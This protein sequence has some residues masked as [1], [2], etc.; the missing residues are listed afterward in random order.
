M[1]LFPKGFSGMGGGLF[2]GGLGSLLPEEA[3][4]FLSPVR[5]NK[6][7]LLGYLAGALQG[8]SLGESIGSG[9]QGMIAGS[10]ADSTAKGQRAALE[11]VAQDQNLPAD[12]RAAMVKSPALAM[13]YLKGFAKPPEFR[14]FDNQYGLS[15]PSFPGGY[16]QGGMIPQTKERDPSKRY[17]QEFPQAV[18]PGTASMI[19]PR[20]VQEAGPKFDDITA[21]RKNF[22]G[23]DE[24]KRWKQ[25]LPS[26]N[27]MVTA[28]NNP[29]KA[30]DL[31]FIYGI[32]KIFDPDSVVRE[33]EQYIIRNTQGLPSEVAAAVNR[34]LGDGQ[35]L[36]PAVRH[37]LATLGRDRMLE[38]QQQ[39]RGV[40]GQ[41]RGIAAEGKIR[42]EL[43][44]SPMGKMSNLP[45]APA[46][47]PAA[48]GGLRG[49]A[50]A[51]P[52]AF[53]QRFAGEPVQRPP[54]AAPLPQPNVRV[55]PQPPPKQDG[56]V[57]T[58]TGEMRRAAQQ[59]PSAVINEARQLLQSGRI[60]LE[61]IQGRLRELGIDP[62][63]LGM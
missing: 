42:P 25:A 22:E 30:A 44:I 2:G 63:L 11:Y 9:L 13:E 28:L 20:Q 54:A 37:Q 57:G 35:Q 60:T 40:E 14:N 27:S 6:N 26:F 34:V 39:F 18:G 58:I 3:Q 10:Q 17:V 41:Y 43:I 56:R 16:R 48:P 21:L 23:L 50:P 15:H 51:A 53:D 38:Y 62:R 1:A 59:D 29:S 52:S 46:S 31:P 7:A 12:L 5:N 45:P 4:G 8:G 49:Q 36:Q 19:P 47:P 61:G 32:A 55:G 24:V 33:G